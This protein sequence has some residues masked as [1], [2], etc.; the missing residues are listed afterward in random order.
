MKN[1]DKEVE[2]F[3]K[4]LF[5]LTLK[6]ID[7]KLTFTAILIFSFLTLLIALEGNSIM[8]SILT[9]IHFVLILAIDI[10]FKE[11]KFIKINFFCKNLK[12]YIVEG[13][14]NNEIYKKDNLY[15][16]SNW[17][18]EKKVSYKDDY[19]TITNEHK[20]EEYFLVLSKQIR[21]DKSLYNHLKDYL[22]DCKNGT[23][24]VLTQKEYNA[25]ME[26][27]FCTN[28]SMFY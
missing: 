25:M 12:S 20:Q 16:C 3:K 13:F 22:K 2:E 6:F 17:S 19:I 21:I 1:Y 5:S 27:K 14:K 4:D 7:T 8:I 10:F 23:I 28:L 18:L 9:I 15:F 11:D 24:L 26:S